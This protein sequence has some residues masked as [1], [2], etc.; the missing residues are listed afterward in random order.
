MTDKEKTQT[1]SPAEFRRRY[2]KL[3]LLAWIIPP[4]FGLSFLVLIGM[5]SFSD[6]FIILTNPLE[7]IFI[8]ANI[9]LAFLYLR[10]YSQPIVDYLHDPD[11]DNMAKTIERIR[12]FPMVFWG[13]L[14]GF[15]VIAPSTVMLSAE[16]YAGYKPHPYDWF[17]IHLVALIVSIIV[18][19]PIF[20]LLFDLFG[21]AAGRLKLT[22]PS[23]TIRTKVFLIGSLVPLLIDTMLIQYY[24]TRT[25]FFSTE[26]FGIWL[27]LEILAIVGSLF[28]VRSFGQSLM[29]LEEYVRCRLS[30]ERPECAIPP[31]QS[32]D[33]LGVLTGH[34]LE[35]LDQQQ[36]LEAQLRHSQKL[37][38]LGQ[39]AGGVAHDFNN[40]LT[41][42]MGF[43]Q[44]IKSKL[45]EDDPVQQDLDHMLNASEKASSLVQ[46]LLAFGR[47]ESF[48]MSP[49]SLTNLLWGIENLIRRIISEDIEMYI[50]LTD[51]DLIIMGDSTLIHQVIM[52]LVT[53]ARDAM[54]DGGS[55]TM[56]S[57]IVEL[58]QDFIATHGYGML[59]VY[60]LTTVSDTGTGMDERTRERIFDPF[61]TTKEIG[62]GT[63]L[64]LSIVY[65]IV[66]QHGGYINCYSEPGIG[67]SFRLYLP[68]I[69]DTEYLPK[70]DTTQS[71]S[72]GTETILLAEDEPMVRILLSDTLK[73]NGYTV[74]E[75]QDGEEAVRKFEENRDKIHLI[76]LDLIMPGKSGKDAHEEIMKIRPDMKAIIMS[77]YA[78]DILSKKGIEEGNINFLSKPIAPAR[79][80]RKLR[81]V[82]DDVGP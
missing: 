61:F 50:D 69:K 63:G 26:T 47:K 4:I 64:G 60:A 1:L 16:W 78:A 33:E 25:G 53:N 71:I 76:L 54:P 32:T 29:P 9:L 42:I 77:G 15:L 39:L 12:R 43:G 82:I 11:N 48:R 44:M 52:N 81:E 28:F 5:F 35:V 13:F 65:G 74:I 24:W 31:P 30:L 55:L 49:L 66:K 14:L 22:E 62:K 59:G 58:D 72:G 51:E 56:T 41:V 3:I 45:G 19:L 46:G 18:G 38:A 36:N 68:L 20:F 37:E 21:K 27:F 17:R 57:R 10:R 6:I 8:L 67:T 2:N 40:I 79:L 34:F 75:A 73:L 70:S 80:L 7:P 23:L